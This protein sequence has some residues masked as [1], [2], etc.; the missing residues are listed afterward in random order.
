MIAGLRYVAPVSIRSREDIEIVETVHLRSVPVGSGAQRWEFQIQLEPIRGDGS[1]VADL[2]ALLFNASKREVLQVTPP[3]RDAVAHAAN[4]LLNRSESVGDTSIRIDSTSGFTIPK[5]TPFTLGSRHKLYLARERVHSNGGSQ[6]TFDIYPGVAPRGFEQH[7]AVLRPHVDP[8][9]GRRADSAHRARHGPVQ[10][11]RRRG[12]GVVL[13]YPAL[14]APGFK[15][16]ETLIDLTA[17]DGTVYRW[18][19]GK[20]SRDGYTVDHSVESITPT[21]MVSTV[22]RVVMKVTLADSVL[23]WFNRLAP[24]AGK[25]LL[26]VRLSVNGT[27][28]DGSL[29][30][31]RGR[32]VEVTAH[33]GLRTTAVY[34]SGLTQITAQRLMIASDADQR[35][36][37]SSDN[38]LAFV[39]RADSLPWGRRV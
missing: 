36:R 30:L 23:T 22:S 18:I 2:E 24:D 9:H 39:H 32:C 8:S 19:D 6:Q 3:I 12:P 34:G 26:A 28:A 33:G 31:F 37:A 1:Q 7:E 14:R 16:L 21:R 35:R 4:V 38:S 11:D 17:P 13:D 25:G 15:V 5:G 29:L 10:L 20:A 27:D